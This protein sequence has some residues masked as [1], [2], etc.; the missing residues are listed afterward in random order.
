MD[1]YDRKLFVLE[2]PPTFW[3]KWGTPVF[4]C[5][6][7]KLVRGTLKLRLLL[8]HDR[9][10]SIDVSIVD[11]DD[12]QRKRYK[13]LKTLLKYNDSAEL[14]MSYFYV[15][16]NKKDNSLDITATNFVIGDIG[17]DSDFIL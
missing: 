15:R 4:D 13:E 5:I 17:E 10:Y 1:N 9:A 8:S 14:T 2:I 6:G 16:A 11:I 7:A 12:E 3:G